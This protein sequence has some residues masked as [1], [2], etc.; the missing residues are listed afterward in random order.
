MKLIMMTTLLLASIMP[1]E[2]GEIEQLYYS[3]SYQEVIQKAQQYMTETPEI[4]AEAEIELRSFVAYS[5]VALAERQQAIE[6]FKAI[7]ELDRDLALDPRLVSPKIIEVF[8]EARAE[9]IL[10]HPPDIIGISASLTSP[11]SLRIATLRSFAFPGLGQVY[12]GNPTKGW[13]FVAGEGAALAGLIVTHFFTEKAHQSYLEASDPAEI[14][15][16]YRVY[17]AW[18]MTRSGFAGIALGIWIYAPLDIL[19]FPPEWAKGR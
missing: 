4:A 18:Y 17:N 8:N 12:A 14:E 19:L 6:E 7:L 16:R 13:G 11:L 5:Y 1:D 2:V 10:A 3:G 15:S 9:F